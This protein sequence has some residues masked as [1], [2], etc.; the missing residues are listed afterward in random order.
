M[1]IAPSFKRGIVPGGREGVRPK[2]FMPNTIAPMHRG[3]T[4]VVRI[5]YR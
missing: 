2:E 3:N 4:I 1:S 5:T